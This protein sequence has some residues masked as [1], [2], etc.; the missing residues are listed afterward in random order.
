MTEALGRQRLALLEFLKRTHRMDAS[1]EAADPFERLAVPGSGR[2][3]AA[4]RIDR[5]PETMLFPGL[6]AGGRR[7]HRDLA[8]GELVR[9]GVFLV[10]LRIAPAAG[11]VELRHHHR[12]VLEP[13]LVDAVLVA[14]QAEQAPVGAHARL[15][16]AVEHPVGRQMRVWMRDQGY[17]SAPCTTSS[18]FPTCISMTAIS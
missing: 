15:G 8:L 10:D 2:A 5:Q 1:D 11:P 17:K 14:V 7:D 6:Y 3:P 4:A 16:D 9:E 12:A 18:R 13:H